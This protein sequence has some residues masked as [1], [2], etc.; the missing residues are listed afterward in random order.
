MKF[1]DD[2]GFRGMVLD[3]RHDDAFCGSL[4]GLGRLGVIGEILVLVL[5]CTEYSRGRHRFLHA[6]YV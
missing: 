3:I 5:T 1:H 4:G 2:T 6:F